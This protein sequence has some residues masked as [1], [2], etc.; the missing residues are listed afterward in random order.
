MLYF[1][2]LSIHRQ[3][4]FALNVSC[5]T[6]MPRIMFCLPRY[7]YCVSCTVSRSVYRDKPVYRSGPIFD[8]VTNTLFVLLQNCSVFDC[9]AKT[10]FVL[11]QNCSVVNCATNTLFYSS[12]TIKLLRL[13]RWLVHLKTILTYEYHCALDI[14]KLKRMKNGSSTTAFPDSL[15]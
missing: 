2:I 13:T 6:K 12:F 5:F 10:L 3:M 4:W 7:G 9:V 8:C 1:A 14:K 11:L 15:L